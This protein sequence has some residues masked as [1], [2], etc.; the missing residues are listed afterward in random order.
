MT[1]PVDAE[2]AHIGGS[3]KKEDRMIMEEKLIN[4]EYKIW[5]K[6]SPFLYDL[7]VTHALEWPTLT[8]Q[9]FPDVERPEGK[10]YV[11]QRLLIGTHTSE[12]AQNYLQIAQ[13]QLPNENVE[14]DGRNNDPERGEAGGYGGADCKINIIQKINHDGE[15]NRARYMPQNPDIIATRTCLGPVY[16][17]DRTRHTS[18]PSSD[19][20]CSPEIKLVSHTKEGYGMSWH[21]T[22][23]GELLTASE[24]TTIC[25]WDIRKFSKDKKT[26]SPV[27]TYTAH[28]AWVE[29]V[30]WSTL[31]ES[32]FASVGDD[33]RMMIWDTRSASSNK[34]SFCV[35]AHTAE[36]N[37]VAFNPKNEFLVA[38]GSADKTVALWDMRNLQH[39]LH[40]FESHQDEI[41][42]LS[43]SPHNETVLASSSGDRRLNIW[44]ISRIGEEQSPEDAEDGPPELLFVHGGHT[45]KISD[46]SWNPNDPWVLCSV[47]EDNICQVWQMASN[48]YSEEDPSISADHLE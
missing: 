35:D 42:Q 1:L 8:C 15:V 44:D 46:F 31:I 6:N 9:W 47:A 40:S 34:A 16:I 32:T 30:A 23:E 45:N 24:D 27:R 28:T 10:D 38:T 13:A 26:L 12:G 37:C 41:L 19:G 7:V 2:S 11:L 33:K 4:E 5:K 29:D 20:V 18:T 14:V 48:I 36:I 25:S 3:Y 39:R 21:P 22:R 43:W 17:F